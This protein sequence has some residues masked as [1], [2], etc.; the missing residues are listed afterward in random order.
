MAAE[1]VG[2]RREADEDDDGEEQPPIVVR[3]ALTGSAERG[4]ACCEL[5]HAGEDA[6]AASPDNGRPGARSYG[7]KAPMPALRAADAGGAGVGAG[8]DA[9]GAAEVARQMALVGEAADRGDLDERHALG[10]EHARTIEP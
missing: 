4:Q 7:A 5:E 10:D 6:P 8:G 1:E 9:G 2:Q 3:V